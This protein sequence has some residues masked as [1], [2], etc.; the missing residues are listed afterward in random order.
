MSKRGLLGSPNFTLI[1]VVTHSPPL[2]ERRTEYANPLGTTI[3]TT[4]NQDIPLPWLHQQDIPLPWL[5]Q[6]DL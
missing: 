2:S 6:L 1:L 3:G 4:L 5:H